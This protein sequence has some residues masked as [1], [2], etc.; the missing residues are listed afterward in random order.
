M[1]LGSG[2]KTGKLTHEQIVWYKKNMHKLT[3]KQAARHL[4]VSDSQLCRI[5]AGQHWQN[6]GIN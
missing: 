3:L 5:R 2:S 6:V 4:P 1:K